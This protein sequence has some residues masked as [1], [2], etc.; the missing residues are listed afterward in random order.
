MVITNV[1]VRHFIDMEVSSV[2][3]LRFHVK[4]TI[5]FTIEEN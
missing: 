5:F 1:Y 3:F 4:L 2:I